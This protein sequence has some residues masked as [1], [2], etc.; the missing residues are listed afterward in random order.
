MTQDSTL[1]RL[2]QIDELLRD[3]EFPKAEA[4][5]ALEYLGYPGRCKGS[6]SGYCKRFPRN[7]MIF[8]ANV[9]CG[10]PDGSIQKIWYG[11]MDLTL[12]EQKLQYLAERLGRLVYVF[13]EMDGRFLRGEPANA[14]RAIYLTAGQGQALFRHKLYGVARVRGR[15]VSQKQPSPKKKKKKVKS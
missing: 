12:E 15:L 2:E 5:L 8:N 7:V 10:M 4:K 9:Y 6:K 1:K 13:Y 3:P 14:E 11:D